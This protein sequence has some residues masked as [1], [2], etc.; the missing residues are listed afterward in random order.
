MMLRRMAQL[1]VVGIALMGYAY[2]ANAAEAE[3]AKVLFGGKATNYLYNL[4]GACPVVN[5]QNWCTI[6]KAGYIGGHSGIDIQTT[7]KGTEDFYSVSSGTVINTGGSYGMI[8]VY[9]S[10]KNVTI[11]YLHSSYR[12]VKI[13]DT[14][15][16]GTLLGKQGDTGATGAF[17]VH[18]EAQSGRQ[19][20]GGGGKPKTIDPVATVMSYLS[21]IQLKDFWSKAAP[22]YAGQKNG[23]DAQFKLVNSTGKTV[24]LEAA[25]LS[26]HDANGNFIKDM[27]VFPNISVYSGQTWQTGIVYT[28]TTYSNGVALPVGTYRVIA[29]IDE[30]F[31]GRWD[32]RNLGQVE[33]VLKA[34]VTPILS[35]LMVTCPSSVNENSSNAGV[36]TATAYY[37]NNSS[38][39]VTPSWSDNSGALSVSSNGSISTSSVSS[40]TYVTITGSYSESGKTVQGGSTVIIKDVIVPPPPVKTLTFLKVSCPTSVNEN[41]SNVGTCVAIAGY[42]DGSSKTV[43]PTW[44]GNSSALS[45]NSSGTLST[46]NVSSNTY[47]TV[48]GSYSESGKTI[49][50]SST[51]LVNNIITYSIPTVT[52][53]SPQTVTLGTPTTFTVIGSG[54]TDSLASWID[55]CVGKTAPTLYTD[56][57]GSSTKRT[58]TCTPSFSPGTKRGVVKDKSGGTVLYDFTITVR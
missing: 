33:F 20:A 22:L 51:V 19:T 11:I 2:S 58:F 5:G 13:G 44:W 15:N 55:Q 37:T 36:C 43:T 4:W 21:S 35:Q 40:N 1:V 3:I 49:Q 41:L 54:L 14:V 24:S 17:H 27:K 48:T 29:K 34:S 46:A 30:N 47:V 12:Y 31:N 45:I 42:S 28:D 53:V 25:Y 9:D 26:L 39:T 18:I 52:S 8:A 38:K 32:G 57:G 6:G 7:T 10:V 16:V 56:V 23:F 50:G